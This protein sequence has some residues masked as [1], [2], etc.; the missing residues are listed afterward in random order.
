M[1]PKAQPKKPAASLISV[2]A[3]CSAIF[4]VVAVGLPMLFDWYTY[5]HPSKGTLTFNFNPAA[6]KAALYNEQSNTAPCTIT[7]EYGFDP[8]TKDLVLFLDT[9]EVRIPNWQRDLQLVGGK[10]FEKSSIPFLNR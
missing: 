3:A 2:L 4:A 10:P 9:S 7:T 8:V 1:A 5:K 6:C